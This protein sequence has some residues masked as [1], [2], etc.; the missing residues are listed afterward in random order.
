VQ[1][2]RPVGALALVLALA[3]PAL[4]AD[5]IAKGAFGPTAKYTGK[6]TATVVRIGERRELR[7]S[8]DFVAMNAVR[9]RLYLATSASASTKIDLGPMK[10]RGSQR[11]RLPARVDV[12]RFRYV[13]AWCV[14]VDEP[15][16]QAVLR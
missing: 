4:A 10:P 15:I 12:K 2:V 11:F 16:T 1:L 13:I 14:A 5:P 8:R 3:A 9:L 6:G 7:L